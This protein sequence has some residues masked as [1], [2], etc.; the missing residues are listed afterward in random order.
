MMKVHL[1]NGTMIECT[2]EEFEELYARGIFGENNMQEALDEF[3]KE[4][5][6]LRNPIPQSPIK[7]PKNTEIMLYGCGMPS[8]S[9]I[10]YSANASAS[11]EQDNTDHKVDE[12]DHEQ[13]TDNRK[14]FLDSESK[15][16]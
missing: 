13:E 11:V 8:S 1:K 2:V 5:S 4:P 3:T 12:V 6:I 9:P 16:P 14:K 7:V 15:T 10:T